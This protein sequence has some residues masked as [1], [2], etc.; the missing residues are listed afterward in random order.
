MDS[1]FGNDFITIED[2]DGNEIEL[3]HLDTIEINGEIYMAFLPTDKD[4][5]DDEYGMIILKVKTDGDEEFLATIDDDEVLDSLFEMFSQRLSE[6]GD[7]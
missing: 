5:D 6:D 4:E 1:E 2:S 3:E 7:S